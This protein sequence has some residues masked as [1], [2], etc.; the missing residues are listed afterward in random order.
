MKSFRRK[1]RLSAL[2]VKRSQT[3]SP[4][5]KL[6]GFIQGQLSVGVSL[7]RAFELAKKMNV[8]GCNE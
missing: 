7:A 4:G 2:K 5:A 1:D 8:A 6:S 3:L